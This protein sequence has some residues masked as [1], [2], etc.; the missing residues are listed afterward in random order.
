MAGSVVVP[1][2]EATTNSVRAR[3][4]R[5]S[6]ACTAA[7]TVESSTFSRGYPLRTPN[8]RRVTSEHRLEPP[9]PR[10]TTSSNWDFTESANVINSGAAFV[11]S[12][13][14]VSQPRALAMIFLCAS[15]FFQSVASFF[16]MRST[17]FSL[18]TRGAA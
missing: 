1:D 15:S 10:T 14:T 16:Q 3:S 6:S 7:G 18:S 9:M 4:S 2:F 5:V 11:I 13:A 12:S 8:S 17:N